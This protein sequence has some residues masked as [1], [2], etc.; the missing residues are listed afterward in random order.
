M[1]FSEMMAEREGNCVRRSEHTGRGME[2]MGW[3][4]NGF[5]DAKRDEMKHERNDHSDVANENSNQKKKKKAFDV[6]RR[7]R[8]E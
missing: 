2:W 3:I 1:R 6:F 7:Q 5:H 8:N 4:E